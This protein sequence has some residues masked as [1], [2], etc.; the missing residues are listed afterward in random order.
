MR[1]GL[2]SAFTSAPTD[3][4]IALKTRADLCAPPRLVRH[5][6]K[7]FSALIARALRRHDT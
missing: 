2:T 3:P 7:A 5:L 4:Y 6:L 1:L